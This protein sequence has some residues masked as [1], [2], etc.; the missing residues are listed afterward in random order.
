M[1]N[2]KRKIVAT[3]A[4][5]LLVAVVLVGTG[6]VQLGG[7][8]QNS[9]NTAED[10]ACERAFGSEWDNTGWIGGNPP[11]L[12]C[13]GPDGQQG[14]MDMPRVIAEQRGIKA[15]AYNESENQT[16]A[17]QAENVE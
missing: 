13:A 10:R 9:E 15:T 3:T 6:T 12:Q 8:V 7:M 17:Q 4:I 16:D 14:Y 5:G 11:Q 1:E 2:L